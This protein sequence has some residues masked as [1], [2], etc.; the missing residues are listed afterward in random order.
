[1]SNWSHQVAESYPAYLM[2]R[3]KRFRRGSVP[4]RRSCLRAIDLVV[5]VL[6]LT[7][8]DYLRPWTRCSGQAWEAAQG[9]HLSLGQ[10]YL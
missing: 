3:R 1:M 10:D 6:F 4:W 9:E 7:V 8:D 2:E 5:L